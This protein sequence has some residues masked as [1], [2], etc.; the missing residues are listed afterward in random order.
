MR[1]AREKNVTVIPAVKTVKNTE[2]QN[3]YK[4]KVAGYARVSTELEEQQT[5]YEAQVAY[6][7]DYI[8]HN[9]DWEMAGIYTDEGITAT[10]TLRRDGFNSMIEDALKG[11]IDLIITKSVSRFARNTV[12]CLSTLRKLKDKG[13][14]VYFEKE[15]IH[16]LDSKG[17]LLITIMSSLAQEESRSISENVTWGHRKRFRDGKFSLAYS[18]FMGYEKGKRG[19]MIINPEQARVVRSM[20]TMYLRG[21]SDYAIAK[22]LTSRGI[23]TPYE[24]DKWNPSTVRSILMNE[25]YKGDARL[26]KSFTV[27]FLTKKKKKNE[28]EVPQYYVKGSHSAI[29]PPMI[30][31]M[32]QEE[33]ARRAELFKEKKISRY[34]GLGLFTTRI[35]CGDCGHWYGPKTWHAGTPNQKIVFQCNCKYKYGTV[36]QTPNLEEKHIKALFTESMSLREWNDDFFCERVEYATAYRSGNVVFSF[37]DGRETQAAL[38]NAKNR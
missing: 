29:V 9:P 34:S 14:E 15:N 17:E 27:D 19:E 13:I 38:A 32:V 10:N 8:S 5:S 4:R 25:K 21:Y 6:Y 36:C 16:T 24:K 37:K 2:E 3:A 1:E 30:F 35:K 20:F 33:R 12:D 7:T 26:Q 22:D 28:G 31:D 18:R 11:K 23:K